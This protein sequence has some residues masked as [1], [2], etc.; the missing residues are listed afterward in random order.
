MK[1]LLITIIETDTY[2]KA[3][4]ILQSEKAE[5]EEVTEQEVEEFLDDK[6]GPKVKKQKLML[7]NLEKEYNNLLRTISSKPDDYLFTDKV[8]DAFELST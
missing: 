3:K 4:A 6:F 8:D 2:S 5:G 1:S 7:L